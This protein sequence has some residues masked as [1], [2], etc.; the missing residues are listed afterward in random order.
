VVDEDFAICQSHANDE[1]PQVSQITTADSF[2]GR[3][4]VARTM[5]TRF[6]SFC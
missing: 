5:F 1:A 4:C 2:V 3:W 6:A